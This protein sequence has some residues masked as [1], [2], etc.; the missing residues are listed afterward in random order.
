M[1]LST[2]TGPPIAGGRLILSNEHMCPVAESTNEF[3][4]ALLPHGPT[5]N[6]YVA[7]SGFSGAAI[8]IGALCAALARLSLARELR[9][10]V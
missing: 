8:L 3:L 7:I 6:P 4:L 10:V 9:K 1:S 2:L 5:A